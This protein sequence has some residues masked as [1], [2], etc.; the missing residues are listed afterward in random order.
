MLFEVLLLCFGVLLIF[1][2]K[3]DFILVSV[4]SAGFSE[5]FNITQ[6]LTFKFKFTSFTSISPS[7]NVVFQQY[8]IFL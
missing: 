2:I 8:A 7:N 6:L 4:Q 3:S 1:D 5:N